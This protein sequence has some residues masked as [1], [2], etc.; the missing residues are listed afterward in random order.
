M[1]VAMAVVVAVVVVVAVAVAVA[2][3]VGVVVGMVVVRENRSFVKP[4]RDG[5]WQ[6]W[7]TRGRVPNL[8]LPVVCVRPSPLVR[9]TMLCG[10]GSN[11]NQG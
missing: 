10:P 8:V 2:V 9:D 4:A 11:E 1:V 3:V 6:P 7:R 5:G